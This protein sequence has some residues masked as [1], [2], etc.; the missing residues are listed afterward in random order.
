LTTSKISS[1][2]GEPSYTGAR[3]GGMQIFGRLDNDLNEAQ[4]VPRALFPRAR[5][6]CAEKPAE[7]LKLLAT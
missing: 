3:S 7:L 6:S 1:F 2:I 5:A 4:A